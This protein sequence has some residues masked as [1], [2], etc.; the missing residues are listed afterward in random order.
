MG[1]NAQ[2]Q[3]IERHCEP[4]VRDQNLKIREKSIFKTIKLKIMA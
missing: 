2:N 4:I 3:E 1:T